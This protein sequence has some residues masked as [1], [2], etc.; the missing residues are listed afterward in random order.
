MTDI[1]L[2]SYSDVTDA[3]INTTLKSKAEKKHLVVSFFMRHMNEFSVTWECMNCLKD[4]MWLPTH[5]HSHY[6]TQS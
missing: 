4:Y 6:L 3:L 1:T 2:S 5:C